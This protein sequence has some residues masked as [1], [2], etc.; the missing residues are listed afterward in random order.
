M[1][2]A[3]YLFL[4]NILLF[5]INF[6]LIYFSIS[7]LQFNNEIAVC[8]QESLYGVQRKYSR[9]LNDRFKH[10]R[11]GRQRRIMKIYHPLLIV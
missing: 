10:A 2:E 4:K 7:L 6:F 8:S 11:C 9:Q 3:Y 1:G 5:I